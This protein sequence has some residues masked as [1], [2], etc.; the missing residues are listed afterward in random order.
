MIDDATF[1]SMYPE[2]EDYHDD[3]D[4]WECHGCG[5]LVPVG[6]SCENCG[7]YEGDDE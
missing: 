4:F 6:E 7:Y 5:D 2:R 1:D 3:D